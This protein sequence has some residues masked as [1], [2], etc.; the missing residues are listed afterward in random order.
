MKAT[1]TT[2]AAPTANG[3]ATISI[4]RSE[5]CVFVCSLGSTYA[6]DVLPLKSNSLVFC[7]AKLI[8]GAV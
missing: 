8:I 6:S 3:T 7:H 4:V 2:I 1:T 5:V